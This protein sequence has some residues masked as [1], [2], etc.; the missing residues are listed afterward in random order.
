[1]QI[2]LTFFASLLFGMG[3]IVSGLANPAKVQNFL[4][5]AGVW[6]PSLAL[7]MAAAVVTTG[8]GYLW[9]FKRR[10]PVLEESF[11][12]PTAT[13]IDL[14]LIGGAAL[15]GI[16]WG[17]VGYCPGPAIVA[18]SLG[19]QETIIFVAAMLAG[20]LAARTLS[21]LTVRSMQADASP[22]SQ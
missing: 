10:R 7:T 13:V 4:D 18:L 5:I 17:L 2:A 11:Q 21:S 12:L 14:K 8:V 1:M 20:M 9:V 6:D 16:G 3:L 19:N 15:F 22:R